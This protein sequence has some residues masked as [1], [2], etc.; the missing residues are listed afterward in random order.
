MLIFYI[1]IL[2]II[3]PECSPHLALSSRLLEAI[4][5]PSVVTRTSTRVCRY[6]HY[7]LLLLRK[8][9]ASNFVL[10]LS[11][12]QVVVLLPWVSTAERVSTLSLLR[13]SLRILL[14]FLTLLVSPSSLMFLSLLLRRT[15][16]LTSSPTS[17]LY[18]RVG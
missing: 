4:S 14:S 16:T 18:P 7:A 9:I 5:A 8:P 11:C 17:K 1:S 15:P 2:E 13:S 10:I 6:A 12:K 3:F